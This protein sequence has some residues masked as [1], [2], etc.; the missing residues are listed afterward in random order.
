M[1]HL[2]ISK[3]QKARLAAGKPVR[4]T[5][6]VTIAPPAKKTAKK[7]APKKAPTA[8]RGL[9]IPG[10]GLVPPGVVVV[11]AMMQRYKRR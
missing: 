7:A 6:T 3:Q 1:E 4:K 5:V 10:R 2:K 8:G 11:P 9:R